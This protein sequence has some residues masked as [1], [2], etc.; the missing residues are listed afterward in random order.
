MYPATS[1]AMVEMGG[2]DIGDAV[3]SS[4]RKRLVARGLKNDQRRREGLPPKYDSD[5]DEVAGEGE[6]NPDDEDDVINDGRVSVIKSTT[7]NFYD[8]YSREYVDEDDPTWFHRFGSAGDVLTFQVSDV[9][10]VDE[11]SGRI[12]G[13]ILDSL[14]NE[15]GRTKMRSGEICEAI[16]DGMKLAIKQP[17]DAPPGKTVG[18]GGT[19]ELGTEGGWSSIAVYGLRALAGCTKFDPQQSEEAFASKGHVLVMAAMKD[20][21]TNPHIG[22]WGCLCLSNMCTMATQST[23]SKVGVVESVCKRLDVNGGDGDVCAAALMCLYK[24]CQGGVYFNCEKVVASKGIELGC[25]ALKKFSGMWE[26]CQYLVWVFREL[27]FGK[28]KEEVKKGGGVFA[29]SLVKERWYDNEQLKADAGVVEDML[30]EDLRLG[31][32]AEDIYYLKQRN[33]G[34]AVG[35]GSVDDDKVISV[36]DQHPLA[37]G[38]AEIYH[39]PHHHKKGR[40][41]GGGGSRKRSG[42][43]RRKKREEGNV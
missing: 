14:R 3:E 31:G 13:D 41:E 35:G 8:T 37:V 16:K 36:M 21:P 39:K 4:W 33:M 9:K 34:R 2:L 43:S 42:S 6:E 1:E 19:H 15:R 18:L 23:L 24:M 22:R 20:H 17:Q 32:S 7:R 5:E 40:G 10:G 30:C 28:M 11:E 38:S 29:T 25:A 27:V 26:I 12:Y